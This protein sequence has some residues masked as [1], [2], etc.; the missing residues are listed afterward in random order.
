MLGDLADNN[1][2]AWAKAVA[3]AHGKDT[4]EA[5]AL[6]QI[7]PVIYLLL[8]VDKGTGRVERDLGQLTQYVS[9]AN[10]GAEGDEVWPALCAEL[11]ADGPQREQDLFTKCDAT[12]EFLFTPYSRECS[13]LWVALH[14]RRYGSYRVRSDLG[15]KQTARTRYAGSL[16]AVRDR[17]RRV[18][19]IL[20]SEASQ[21]TRSIT[22]HSAGLP[23]RTR[24]RRFLPRRLG[25]AFSI[26]GNGRSKSSRRREGARSHGLVSRAVHLNS[27]RTVPLPSG[28][29]E[30]R[31]SSRRGP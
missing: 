9:S 2:L 14:G 21:T 20:C 17:Q 4:D 26:S 31:G 19:G 12:Q 10:G 15:K 16:L 27:G 5:K 3:A 13:R 25:L 29:P 28:M 24:L 22:G 6:E 11:C 1:R 18:T 23:S 7:R 8:A 30:S